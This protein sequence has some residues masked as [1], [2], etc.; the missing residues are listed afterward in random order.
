M[1]ELLQF[2]VI[3]CVSVMQIHSSTADEEKCVNVRMMW[4][5]HWFVLCLQLTLAEFKVD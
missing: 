4:N 1:K 2:F 3:K 5:L